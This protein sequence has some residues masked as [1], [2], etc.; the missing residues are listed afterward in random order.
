MIV[1][2]AIS[3]FTTAFV[4]KRE[5]PNA[6]IVVVGS[7]QDKNSATLCA[8]AMINCYAELPCNALDHDPIKQKFEYALESSKKWPQYIERINEYSEISLSQPTGKTYCLLNSNST[9]MECKTFDYI[10]NTVGKKVPEI[11]EAFRII[12]SDL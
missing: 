7:F 6:K 11:K 4:L 10:L 1:G 2:G 12:Q 9:K 5:D 8:G 3:A